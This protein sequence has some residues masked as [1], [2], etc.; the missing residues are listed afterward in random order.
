MVL[1]PGVPPLG[2]AGVVALSAA[3]TDAL[4][5]DP[6]ASTTT[7]TT[8]SGG[9]GGA[10]SGSCRSSIECA[11]PKPVCDTV[12]QTCVECLSASDCSFVADTACSLGKC[13]CLVASRTYCPGETPAPDGGT[14]PLPACVDTQISD[15][16]CGGCNMPCPAGC[17]MGTCPTAMGTGGSNG[18]G[19]SGADAGIA[20]AASE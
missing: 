1:G 4:H 16:N 2:V 17:V 19:G 20:D 9:T 12:T 15:I 7:G 6:P 18:T 13:M 14:S 8:G 5:L 3:C 11:Y 10:V